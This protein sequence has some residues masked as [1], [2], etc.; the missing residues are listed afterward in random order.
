M[1]GFLA[2]S[3]AASV[4]AK[5]GF[6]KN[7]TNWIKEK[8]EDVQDRFGNVLAKMVTVGRKIIGVAQEQCEA[9]NLSAKCCGYVRTRPSIGH[10][11]G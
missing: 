8:A 3:E 5:R 2:V 9:G 7:A 6:L 10:R 4:R 11:V 1:Q